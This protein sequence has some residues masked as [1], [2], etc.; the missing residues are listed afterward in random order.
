MPVWEQV[1]YNIDAQLRA[2]GFAA[3]EVTD[4]VKFETL[5]IEVMRTGNRWTVRAGTVRGAAY[6]MVAAISA[7]VRA[8][9]RWKGFAGNGN[10]SIH[11]ILRWHFEL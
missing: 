1:L 10:M 8:F 7:E 9:R 11:L 2:D 4:A 5:A 3:T 6:E